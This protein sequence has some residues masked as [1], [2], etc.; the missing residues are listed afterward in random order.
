MKFSS[1]VLFPLPFDCLD[2]S[3]Y[4]DSIDRD[5]YVLLEIER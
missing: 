2:I 1:T 3:F 5:S 4:H